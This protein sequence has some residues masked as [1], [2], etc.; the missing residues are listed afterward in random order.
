M[1]HLPHLNGF[2]GEEEALP[3]DCRRRQPLAGVSLLA[4]AAAAAAVAFVDRRVSLQSHPG[5]LWQP[6]HD[7][8]P[9]RQILLEHVR[10]TRI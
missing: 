9:F 10:M 7:G 3:Q 1:R 4:D 5:R 2:A 6:V 8:A